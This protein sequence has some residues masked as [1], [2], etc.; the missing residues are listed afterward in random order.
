MNNSK[1]KVNYNPKLSL[2]QNN[3]LHKYKSDK[4]LIFNNNRTYYKTNKS[5]KQ[6]ALKKK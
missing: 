5:L 6:I 1:Y 4:N 2:S 3:Y